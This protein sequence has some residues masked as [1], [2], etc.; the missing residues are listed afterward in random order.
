MLPDAIYTVN[1]LLMSLWQVPHQLRQQPMI[2][3]IQV[4][5]APVTATYHSFVRYR[6]QK[7]YELSITPQVCFLQKLLN[8][9][10]DNVL[11]RI[12]IEDTVLQ[13]SVY[14]YRDAELKPVYFYTDAENTPVYV[15]TDGETNTLTDDFLIKV[16]SAILFEKA[17]MAALVKA[18]CLPGKKFKIELV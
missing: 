14:L 1:Y 12:I 4:L 6:R 3:Y 13:S 8:D 16:P 10:Y 9:R 17:E 5:I 2:A 7:L 11:R 18:F 15:Y